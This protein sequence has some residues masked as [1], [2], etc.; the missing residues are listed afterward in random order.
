MSIRDVPV[1][2]CDGCGAAIDTDFYITR[3][4]AGQQ[5]VQQNPERDPARHFCCA[6]CEA[7]WGAQFPREGL[8]GPAWDERAWW[9]DNV[10][11][12]GE[13]A[14]VRTA[15]EEAPLMDMAF[16]DHDPEPLP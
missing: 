2:V 4:P 16:H 6:A 15:H 12:C 8:W 14:R 13:R 3:R 10:G 5:I 1:I 9:C 11:P 7:W